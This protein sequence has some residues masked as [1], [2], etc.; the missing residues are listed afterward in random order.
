MRDWKPRKTRSHHSKGCPCTCF[1]P[2]HGT[3]SAFSKGCRCRRCKI[4]RAVYNKAYRLRTKP[5]KGVGSPA[6]TPGLPPPNSQPS[7]GSQI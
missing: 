5:L 4:A 1:R 2:A 6:L 3:I 7:L